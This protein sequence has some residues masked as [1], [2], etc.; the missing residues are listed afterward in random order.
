MIVFLVCCVCVKIRRQEEKENALEI[1]I[2]NQSPEYTKKELKLREIKFQR[3]TQ[4]KKVFQIC[5]IFTL[6]KK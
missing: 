1:K 6:Y 3:H 4:V 2:K 5:G